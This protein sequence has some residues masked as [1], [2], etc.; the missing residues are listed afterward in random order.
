MCRRRRIGAKDPRSHV[1]TTN[2]STNDTADVADHSDRVDGRVLRG[3]R[4]R[5]ALMDALLCLLRES[6]LQPRAQDI[7]DRAGVSVRSLF[8]HFTDLQA[9]RTELV[10]RQRRLAESLIV[11]LDMTM[12]A[13]PT[14]AERITALVEMRAHLWEIVAPIHTIAVRHILPEASAKLSETVVWLYTANREQVWRWFEDAIRASGDDPELVL[15]AL[16]SS[17]SFGLWDNLRDM[18]GLSIE[19]S[20]A[21]MVRLARAALVPASSQ[22]GDG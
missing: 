9:L 5:E 11:E 1:S 4:N 7:A 15:D 21:V 13:T 6:T 2:E 3:Q 17:V 22:L 16:H 10:L 20:K 19:R 12:A 14:P 8:Q 18:Q